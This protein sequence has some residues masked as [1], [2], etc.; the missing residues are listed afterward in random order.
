MVPQLSLNLNLTFHSV[1]ALCFVMHQAKVRCSACSFTTPASIEGSTT[2]PPPSLLAASLLQPT[3]LAIPGRSDLDVALMGLSGPAEVDQALS[4]QQIVSW[5]T[6]YLG[7][8]VK[9]VEVRKKEVIDRARV[10]I[11]KVSIMVPTGTPEHEKVLLDVD[12]CVGNTNGPRGV[13]FVQKQ[14]RRMVH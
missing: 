7:A 1:C 13:S 8:L 6:Q 14:V 5:L 2:P 4:K 9:L 11:L 10:P 3:G 12:I